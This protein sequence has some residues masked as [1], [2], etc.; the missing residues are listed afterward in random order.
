MAR[1][2]KPTLAELSASFPGSVFQPTP[3]LDRATDHAPVTESF[4]VPASADSEGRYRVILDYAIQSSPPPKV[5]VGMT[6]LVLVPYGI[7]PAAGE[8]AVHFAGAPIL[9]F[10]STLAGQTGE[11]E[12]TPIGSV[13]NSVEVNQW[14]LE[15]EAVQSVVDGLGAID[16][17]G[18]DA[19][20]FELGRPADT[21]TEDITLLFGDALHYLAWSNP[22]SG[23]GRFELSH[24]LSAPAFVGD[25]SG[26]TSLPDQHQQNTDTG[27]TATLF[28]INS[29][30]SGDFAGLQFRTTYDESDQNWDIY[31]N[32]DL[33]VVAFEK[34]GVPAVLFADGSALTNLNAS[35]LTSG[36]VPDARLSS[37]VPLWGAG[38]T[39]LSIAAPTTGTNRR[40]LYLAAPT[41]GSTNHS[42]IADGA[43]QFGD[44]LT[45]SKALAATTNLIV[46]R[47]TGTSF[48]G[49]IAVDGPG[50]SGYAYQLAGVE[51]W[52]TIIATGTGSGEDLLFFSQSGTPGIVMTLKGGT[53]KGATI[54]ASGTGGE[55][56]LQY[57]GTSR[58]KVNSTG[59]GF[60]GVTPV[61]QQSMEDL[62]S[63]PT[64]SDFNELL[65]ILRSYGLLATSE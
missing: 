49:Q 27:T 46:A 38:D 15:L 10:D 54:N 13:L 20:V 63:A 57:G 37:N 3:W 19:L 5:T 28:V 52:V 53:A 45:V 11:V 56:D 12:Y 16:S 39:K 44:V 21:G 32:A 36:T 55:I 1:T 42:L 62:A 60:F 23:D 43:G 40:T 6:E 8:V 29:G 30:R 34:D 14:Q 33:G 24:A 48:R 7:T 17:T 9:E 2:Y 25:G 41:G 18:T 4:T 35:E 51:K 50:G 22:D 61:V 58:I 65:G 47:G 59:I 31:V 26:L 64:E